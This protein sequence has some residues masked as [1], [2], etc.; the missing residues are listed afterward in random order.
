MH[1]NRAFYRGGAMWGFVPVLVL[2]FRES[3]FILI[4]LIQAAVVF[5][6]CIASKNRVAAL[7]IGSAAAVAVS[8]IGASRYTALDVLCV[9]GATLAAVS[10]LTPAGAGITGAAMRA[11]VGKVATLAFFL[12][13]ALAAVWL[14]IWQHSAPVERLPS[15]ERAPVHALR[16]RTDRGS[17]SVAMPAEESRLEMLARANAEAEAHLRNMGH[18]VRNYGASPDAPTQGARAAPA[19]DKR[20]CLELRDNA[21]VARCVGY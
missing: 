19:G 11:F 6:L 9:L 21:A 12:L 7:G 8:I 3:A 16:P 18:P 20:H 14:L 17:N 2:I 1:G 4:A 15:E 10:M 13:C 5:F